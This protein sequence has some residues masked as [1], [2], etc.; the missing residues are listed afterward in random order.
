VKRGIKT[1]KPGK[2]GRNIY[3]FALA[4]ESFIAYVA[5]SHVLMCLL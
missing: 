4:T 3:L 1:P 2:S 5:F